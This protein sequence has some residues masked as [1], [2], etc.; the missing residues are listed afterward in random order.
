MSII[1]DEAKR[2]ITLSTKHSTYQ[3]KADDYGYLWHLY[4]GSRADGQDFS[5][6]YLG[7][8]VGFSGQP[9]EEKDSRLISLDTTPQEYPSFGV[10]DYRLSGAEVVNPDGSRCLSF[11]YVSHEVRNGKYSI[12]GLPASYDQDGIAKTLVITLKDPSSKLGVHLYY[13]VFEELDII[14][15]AAEFFNEGEGTIVLERV[16]SAVLDLPFGKWDLIHFHGRHC[17]ER[18][19]GR[20]PMGHFITEISS[21]RGMSSHQHNPFVI[22]CDTTSTIRLS[23][24]ATKR[25]PR[26]GAIATA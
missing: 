26:T 8:D 7:Q 2:M 6:Q 10:G 3:M 1:F 25:R 9:Y 13:G 12:P 24:F 22:L 15:R 19:F 17:M 23:F 18:Q 21:G 14:T 11:R 20:A 5:Y 16:S 4:Y